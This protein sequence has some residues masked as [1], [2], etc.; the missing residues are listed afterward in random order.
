DKDSAGTDDGIPALA[1]RGFH[2]DLYARI[3]DDG[4]PIVRVLFQEQFETW[5]RNDA[6]RDTMLRE[7]L[8]TVD[9]DRNF[10]TRGEDRHVRTTVGSSDL[11]GAACA[12]IVLVEPV[13]QLRQVLPR[14]RK[15]AWAIFR[16]ERK[17]PAFG[18][19]HRVTRTKHEQIRNGAQ[20]GEMFD[21]LMR[22]SV[23]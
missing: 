4:A 18:G 23:F 5:N 13:A 17:L 21:R 15:D 12:H 10:G 7:Q 9:R 6:R 19:F 11:I 16:L 8:C 22:R 20:R 1:D 2:A 3:P 14:Q